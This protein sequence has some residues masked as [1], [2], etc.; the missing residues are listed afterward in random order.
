[1]F[2]QGRGFTEEKLSSDL[3][4][5]I[6]DASKV[7]RGNI[8]KMT[9]LA[10]SG[11]PGGSMS[12]IEIYLMLY[13]MA[14]VDPKDTT[15]D[16]RDRIIISH[17]HIHHWA[18]LE[19]F[20][21]V[22]VYANSETIKEIQEWGGQMLQKLKN[23]KG[24]KAIPYKKVIVPQNIIKPGEERIDG[25]LFR[26]ILPSQEFLSG[27]R[28]GKRVLFTELPE[29]K[30]I[31]HHHL[32]YIG[33]HFPP[34]PISARIEM[35][36]QLKAENY[37]WVMAGHGIPLGSEFFDKAV[38]YYETAQKLIEESPDVKTAREKLIKA[39]PDYWGG[40]LDLL[41]PLHF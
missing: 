13:N 9:T 38:A 34:P 2:E 17:G 15:R 40:L 11:H 1:M 14:N 12:S 27:I 30:A 4:N 29:Q 33:L 26:F 25:V 32:A 8:I 21:G 23:R 7:C 18:G 22:P 35:L 39:Y 36:K 24:D 37:N 28:Y 16:D 41:L 10:M 6:S 5:K 20:P 3:K 19:M 31:I